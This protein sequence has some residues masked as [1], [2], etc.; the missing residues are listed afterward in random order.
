MKF[1]QTILSS[2]LALALACGGYNTAAAQTTTATALPVI[3][4]PHQQNIAGSERTLCYEML[5]NV[6]FDIASDAAWLTARKA[7]NNVIYVHAEANYAKEPRTG[8]LTFTSASGDYAQTL[9][10]VQ[11][12][13]NSA[14]YIPEDFSI[15]PS[16]ATAN[17]NQA[18]QGIERTYDGDYTTLFHT[19]WTPSKFVVSE[20]NPAILT[21]QFTETERIDYVKYVPRSGDNSGGNGNF[22]LVDVYTQCEGEADFTL[23]GSYDWAFSDA[24]SVVTFS[25]PLIKPV[26]IK[27]V[28]K[29]GKSNFASCAEMEFMQANPEKVAFSAFFKDDVCSELKDGIT[30]ADAEAIENPFFRATVMTMLNGYDKKYRVADYRV[31]LSPYVLSSEWNAQGKLY[32]QLDGPTG[33][34]I[35]KGTHAIV[36][37]GLPEGAS[38]PLKVVAWYEGKIG[39]N[40]DGGNPQ[41]FT[42]TL[43]NG[44]NTIT[45]NFDYDGLA[46]V[47][48]YANTRAEYEALQLSNPTV[49]VHFV[50]GQ[51]NG[52]LTP[53]MSNEEMHEMCAN[54]KS[55]FMDC[56]GHKVHSV[57]T[58]Q[59]LKDY[60]RAEDRTTYGYRQ[61]MNVLDSLI[62]W[63]HDV[64]GFDKY[65]RVPD[66][67][68]FAY[69]NYTYY[70]FQGGLGVSFHLDQESRVMS[71]YKL[72]H[73]DDDVIWGL[74]HEWGHQHQM[75]PYF[76]WGGTAEVTNNVKSYTNIMRMGYHSSDKINHWPA[77][78]Q[79]FLNDNEFSTG[80]VVSSGRRLAYLY[81]PEKFSWNN[82]LKAVCEAMSDSLIKPVS[83][84]KLLGA[85]ISDVGVGEVLCPFIMAYAYFSTHGKPT[86]APDWYESLRQN[87]NENGSQVE[88][89]GEADKYELIASAQNNNKNGKLAVLRSKYP[90][91]CW[92]TSNYITADHCGAYDNNVPYMMNWIRK[93]SRLTG[94]N[95]FPYFEQWG[96]L[97]TVA[98]Q[99]GDYGTWWYVCT[100][101]MYD[102][103]K[104]DMDALV[105][106]RELQEMPEGMVEEIS[107]TPD[108]FGNTPVI[109]N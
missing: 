34:N 47:C 10:V 37:S 32:D 23:Y 33:I 107:N 88:K 43:K 25:N 75:I 76:C 71:C 97:R 69:V 64:M 6:D 84:N 8:H 19:A 55:M 42:Y 13:D 90:T 104:A 1:S 5:A 36:V 79:H 22:G 17:N 52:Y 68:T 93:M 99:I 53:E 65:N 18:A 67:H 2:A 26:A 66:N 51:V 20:S 74:S 35:S 100:Q 30:I 81:G 4:S 96:F 101:E 77:A 39:G 92:V 63:E 70:M 61:F 16:S 41:L 15:K 49:K 108:L 78:R 58:S 46:Y 82:K 56:F 94:Y 106:S 103:F 86:I 7:D 109:P 21:Y 72:I 83:E 31:R 85:H 38:L 87:D 73:A 45:Y 14:Q 29:S 27:F 102:E 44:L 91:S 11:G 28:V 80:T 12:A 60:C 57:W 3:F 40:F 50:N 105:A 98:M 62:Y 24:P 54:A 9:E 95:L 59:G 89:Q 48:Y